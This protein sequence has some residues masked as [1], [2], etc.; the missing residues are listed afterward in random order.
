MGLDD[1]KTV[2]RDAVISCKKFEFW[3]DGVWNDFF[4]NKKG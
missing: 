1:K 2:L 4:L 3:W